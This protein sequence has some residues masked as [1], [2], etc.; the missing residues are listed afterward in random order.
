MSESYR[1]LREDL[2]AP[3]GAGTFAADVRKVKAW[4]AALP[5]ANAQATEVELTRALQALLAQRLD[6]TQR[7]AALDEIRPVVLEAATAPAAP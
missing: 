5:R 2:P 6:S 7:L 4:I 1:R 3:S